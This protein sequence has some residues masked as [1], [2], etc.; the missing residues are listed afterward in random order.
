MRAPRVRWRWR[1]GGIKTYSGFSVKRE[2]FYWF[3]TVDLD[4]ELASSFRYSLLLWHKLL[5]SFGT[6]SEEK[7]LHFL[8]EECPRFRFEWGQAVFVDQHGLV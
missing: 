4:W 3:L 5:R 8:L 6:L 7:F 2:K 1:K